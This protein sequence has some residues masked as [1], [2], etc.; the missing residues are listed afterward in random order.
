MAWTDF[1]TCWLFFTH[2]IH[3][4]F[5]TTLVYRLIFYWLE[6]LMCVLVWQFCFQNDFVCQLH[7]FFRS[8]VTYIKTISFYYICIPS[9]SSYT[10]ILFCCIIDDKLVFYIL[11][12]SL[13]RPESYTNVFK[14]SILFLD[15]VTLHP[16]FLL[17][18]SLSFPHNSKL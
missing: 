14:T 10:H 6:S 1:S 12:S 4:Y 18:F 16:H 7:A 5:Y 9:F 2:L 17:K 15:S 8:F 11:S 13:N 3:Y